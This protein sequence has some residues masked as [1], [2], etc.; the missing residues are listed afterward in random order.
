QPISAEE[1]LDRI[2]PVI[3]SVAGKVQAPLS[4]DTYKARTAEEAI[5]AGAHIINDVW[6]AK[7][8]PEIADVAAQYDVPIILMHNRENPQ[9]E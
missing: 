3:H 5:K 4:V 7:R 9:Y 1:E 2:L 6:G 8:D